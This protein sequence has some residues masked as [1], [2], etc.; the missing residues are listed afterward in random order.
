MSS[1]HNQS[2]V[3]EGLEGRVAPP[4]AT[5]ALLPIKGEPEK[6]P[7]PSKNTLTSRADTM[8][9]VLQKASSLTRR[10]NS[11]DIPNSRQ[12]GNNFGITFSKPIGLEQ[13]TFPCILLLD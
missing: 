4:S 12:K 5:D 10:Q 2:N 11:N 6:D 8:N 1:D 7:A 9:K 13:C 3:G